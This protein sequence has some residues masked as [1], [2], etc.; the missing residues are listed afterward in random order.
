MYSIQ[1]M[2]GKCKN[3]CCTGHTNGYQSFHTQCM[4]I[5]YRLVSYP[6]RLIGSQPIKLF[7]TQTNC[8]N[9]LYLLSIFK[10]RSVCINKFFYVTSIF[11][12]DLQREKNK[13]TI[14]WFLLRRSKVYNR[15]LSIS[16]SLDST[17][18]SY[19]ISICSH[20]CVWGI[21]NE[22]MLGLVRINL[23]FGYKTTQI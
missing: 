3:H 6:A 15:I 21:L 20:T 7:C 22:C 9:M 17:E 8:Q 4:F 14:Y 16:N 1:R 10:V 2:L 13:Y 23:W 12:R 18:L 11:K 5:S 19:A